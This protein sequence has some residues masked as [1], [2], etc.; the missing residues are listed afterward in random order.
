MMYSIKKA[1]M[2]IMMLFLFFLLAGTALHAQPCDPG[3]DPDHPIECPI[4]SGVVFLI[5]AGV[6]LAAR[7]VYIAKKKNTVAY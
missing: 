7:K 2:K 1:G 6:G 3:P 4:D 5:I